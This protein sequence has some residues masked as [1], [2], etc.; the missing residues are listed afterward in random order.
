M[1]EEEGG[2]QQLELSCVISARAPLLQDHPGREGR[3]APH[4]STPGTYR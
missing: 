3:Q 4:S 1:L 2:G